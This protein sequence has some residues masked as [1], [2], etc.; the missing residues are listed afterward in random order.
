MEMNGKEK[1]INIGLFYCGFMLVD[2]SDGFKHGS[3][4]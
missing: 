1:M 3:R 2:N 4:S